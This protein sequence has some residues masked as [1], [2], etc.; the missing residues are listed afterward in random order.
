MFTP[1]LVRT[2]GA[3][4]A[5]R[6]RWALKLRRELDTLRLPPPSL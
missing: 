1:I 2:T 5:A 3:N 4:L 6:V